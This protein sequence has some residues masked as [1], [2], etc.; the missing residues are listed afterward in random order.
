MNNVNNSTK[1]G[2]KVLSSVWFTQMGGSVIGVV[3][4]E[5]QYDGLCF[6]IGNGAGY[7]QQTDEKYIAERGA[8][9]PY[10]VG[11]ELLGE[12]V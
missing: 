9:F 10:H 7:N 4:V 8:L 1:A 3:A 12:P 11:V 5:T 6:Y 2:Y